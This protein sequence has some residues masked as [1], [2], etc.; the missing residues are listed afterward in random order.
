MR[1]RRCATATAVD[2]F[3][4]RAITGYRPD[5][6]S[7]GDRPGIM[8]S[9]LV[10]MKECCASLAMTAADTAMTP[11]VRAMDTYYRSDQL[12]FDT[13]VNPSKETDLPTASSENT[14][15]PVP[16]DDTDAVPPIATDE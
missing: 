1:S 11:A 3:G 15:E 6:R 12:T 14:A 16:S 2:A 8:P 13:I 10:R 5:R 4:T 9:R 7:L